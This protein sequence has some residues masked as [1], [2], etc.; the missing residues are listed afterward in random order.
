MV[1]VPGLLEFAFELA[2]ALENFEIATDEVHVGWFGWLAFEL[3]GVPE[4]R[5]D[6]QM[7]F[8]G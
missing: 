7:K 5:L 2:G 8:I 1:M 4:N 6:N 3:V